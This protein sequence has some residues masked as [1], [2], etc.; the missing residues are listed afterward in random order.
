MTSPLSRGSDAPRLAPARPE[1]LVTGPTYRFTVLTSRLI[2]MEHSPTGAFTDA[3]TQL[4]TTR[5][6]G[7]PP[8]FR[9]TTG[10]DRVEVVTE[11]LH[12]T[13]VP[14]L[15]F[16]RSGLNVR[17]RQASA[18]PHGGAWYHGDTWDPEETFPTNLGGTTRTLDEV[19]GRTALDPGLLSLTGIAVLDDSAS[20]LLTQDEWVSPRAPGHDAGSGGSVGVPGSSAAD[21][22]R[23]GAQRDP[24][25]GSQ[26]TAREVHQAAQD[27]YLF[28]YAQDYRAALNDF[29]RLTGPSPLVPRA[30]LGN[31]WSRYHAYSAEEYLA[32]MD[33]FAAEGLPFS[34]AVIDMDWH[35]V[36]IDPAIGTGWTGYTWNRDLFPDPRS[37][38]EALHQRDM[39]V[40]LNVHPAQGV[41]RHE[42]AYEAVCTDLGLDP[43][44][45]DDVPFSITDRDFVGAYLEQV[46]H[47]L[48]E[49]GV[50]FW[51][52]DWQQG[53]TTT[54]PGLDPLWMIN[55][56]HYLDSGRRGRRP[57]TFS[58]YA[59]PSSH[60]TPVGF[61]GD[62]VATW[63]SLRFQPEFT[64]TA[65]N[66]GY[67]WWSNDIGG[68]MLGQRDDDMAARWVQLGCF[69]PVNRL[70]STS[71]E[72]NSKEPWR[73]RRDARATMSAYLRLRHRLVPYLYTWARRSVSEGVGP[74]RPVYHDYPEQAGA[75]ELRRTFFFGDLLVVPFTSPL[76]PVTGLGREP[77]WLPEGVWYDLPTGR[78]Y[79]A[80]GATSEAGEGSG[81]R[82]VLS[83]PLERTVV[84]AR[85]GSVIPLA[86]SVDEPAAHNPRELELV[87]VP[88]ADG[89]TVLEEDDGSASP[90]P[91]AVARTVIK[92]EW[93]GC[94]E[95][96]HQEPGTQARAGATTGHQTGSQGQAVVRIRLE[97]AAHVVPQARRL[98]LRLLAG[99][100]SGAVLRHARG[101]DPS[102]P[103]PSE[104]A[105]STA[106]PVRRVEADGFTLG[107]GTE[108]DLGRLSVQELADGVEVVL[109]DAA[110][111]P[112]AWR[113]EVYDLLE[114][115][116]LP[117]EV[118]DRSWAAVQRGL[119][120]TALLAE[121]EALG[122]PSPLRSAV[123]E[124]L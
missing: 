110:Q 119:G 78:R 61:S 25:D 109:A 9:V 39:L 48:E 59:D 82:L 84:L 94:Q 103:E 105:G 44:A 16:T 6:L 93:V 22:P 114:A 2:R 20:L 26:G 69:S 52:L 36:D 111:A 86:G 87:V 77:A 13:H 53:G 62:T 72:F 90:G 34:V 28:G 45:G 54:L 3:A 88:G 96:S 7:E 104:P 35:L 122:L 118:K 55:H 92:L 101:H 116:Q 42:E 60:R 120:G 98:R 50:D 95:Q 121:L 17:L 58:R 29:F 38:L 33:R 63:D 18:A 49:Q 10:P 113:Q 40:S 43:A 14:S 37:F 79:D 5:D 124:L 21:Y 24:R 97:G 83:R 107:A 91:E 57:V 74:V 68:H 106:L 112:A 66:I 46:H 51:W 56:V 27:L 100:C 80:T 31:W 47:P 71:S 12:L 115:A 41:R 67:Y 8:A 117:Y 73:Y 102:A 76:D 11:H 81:R 65:A 30:L 1:A 70:H 64:A 89:G 4:V 19:D 108:V 123:A 75:Y 85:A 23:G 32:L 99:S 15:G